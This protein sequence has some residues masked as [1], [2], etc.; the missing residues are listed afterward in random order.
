MNLT[1]GPQSMIF[2]YKLATDRSCGNGNDV[3]RMSKRDTVSSFSQLGESSFN[4]TRGG[5]G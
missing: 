2:I 1:D 3:D 5:G 4:I